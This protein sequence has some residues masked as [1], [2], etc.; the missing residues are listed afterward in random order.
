MVFPSHSQTTERTTNISKMLLLNPASDFRVGDGSGRNGTVR[1]DGENDTLA[2]GANVVVG[3]AHPT[4]IANAQDG[5]TITGTVTR[6]PAPVISDYD[7]YSDVSGEDPNLLDLI[8]S[9]DFKDTVQ[10]RVRLDVED[11]TAFRVTSEAETLAG[12]DVN[13]M[14]ADVTSNH[15]DRLVL[16]NEWKHTF[17]YAADGTKI[18]PTFVDVPD[19]TAVGATLVSGVSATEWHWKHGANG[20]GLVAF[21]GGNIVLGRSVSGE[22]FMR[23]CVDADGRVYVFNVIPA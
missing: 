1:C 16:F 7:T 18:E 10:G 23:T 8:A 21:S 9:D 14:I 20:D 12:F 17:L 19:D 15:D 13:A 3:T 6:V 11:W 22:D 4:G 2:I 5:A